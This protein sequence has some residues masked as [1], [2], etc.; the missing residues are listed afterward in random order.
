MHTS[1]RIV[2]SNRKVPW[3]LEKTAFSKSA[4]ESQDIPCTDKGFIC[5]ERV[6]IAKTHNLK[7]SSKAADKPVSPT[8]GAHNTPF[9]H[10]LCNV[11]SV[12]LGLH[13]QTLYSVKIHTSVLP[14]SSSCHCVFSVLFHIPVAYSWHLED[15]S[16]LCIFLISSLLPVFTHPFY[17]GAWYRQVFWC[18]LHNT[19]SIQPSILWQLWS[20]MY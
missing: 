2:K 6:I 1:Q 12:F 8:R 19:E 16:L 9:L 10:M 11:S 15:N 17:S 4:Q 7:Q 18:K 13:L 20:K 5:Q 3:D 14:F